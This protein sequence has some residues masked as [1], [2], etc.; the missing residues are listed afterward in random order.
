MQ[1]QIFQIHLINWVK[2]GGLPF[3]VNCLF[4]K[5]YYFPEFSIQNATYYA[6]TKKILIMKIICNSNLKLPAIFECNFKI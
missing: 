6:K 3:M 4:W 5:F 1:F 2:N